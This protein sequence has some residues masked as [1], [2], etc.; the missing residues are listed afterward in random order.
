M[1]SPE[2]TEGA[3]GRKTRHWLTSAFELAITP[4]ML[5]KV[6]RKPVFFDGWSLY[7]MYVNKK[8]TCQQI[9]D[10]Y[11]RSEDLVHR[12]LGELEKELGV[13]VLRD[14]N[15]AL[16]L[17]HRQYSGPFVKRGRTR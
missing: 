16:Y 13:P 8:M 14:R 12:R 10:Y 1:K 6:G 3:F 9:A 11:G 7:D 5:A 17:G 15:D 2:P 4:L